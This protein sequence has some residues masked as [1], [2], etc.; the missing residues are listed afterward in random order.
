M[1]HFKITAIL[2]TAPLIFMMVFGCGEPT[3]TADQWEQ[4]QTSEEASQT[5]PEVKDSKAEK[6]RQYLAARD[7]VRVKMMERLEKL[8]SKDYDSHIEVIDDWISELRLLYVPEA[9]EELHSLDLQY[10][11][12]YRKWL[13]KSAELKRIL[14]YGQEAIDRGAEQSAQERLDEAQDI[15]DEI[16]E[17]DD[18]LIEL[19]DKRDR[20]YRELLR[21]YDLY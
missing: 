16:A 7:K 5:A 9:C 18:E 15:S 8:G 10:L 12:T 11:R 6:L 19:T 21:E 17:L 4:K 20:K 13:D 3:Y 14:E 1:K 2:L